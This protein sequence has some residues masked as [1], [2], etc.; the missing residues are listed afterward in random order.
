[1]DESVRTGRK[2][3]AA[4]TGQYRPLIAVPAAQSP[5]TVSQSALTQEPLKPGLTVV[6]HLHPPPPEHSPT[7]SNRTD[8]TDGQTDRQPDK[9]VIRSSAPSISLIPYL[10]ESPPLSY[11]FGH[12]GSAVPL[13]RLSAF[14]SSLDLRSN[15]LGSSATQQHH[16]VHPVKSSTVVRVAHRNSLSCIA[17]FL[18]ASSWPACCFLR[19]C[20]AGDAG[21]VIALRFGREGRR[22]VGEII[23]RTAHC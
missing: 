2:T 11:C 22:G 15:A 5:A 8:R 9:T 6:R 4:R 13:L 20:R 16:I 14:G 12:S 18:E 19:P 7:Q 3:V 10:L 21:G 23:L 17:F 1:L